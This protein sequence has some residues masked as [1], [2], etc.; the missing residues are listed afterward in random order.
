MKI[1]LLSGGSGTRLW[2]LSND[3]RA[4][5]FLKVLHNQET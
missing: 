5:Q 1:I 3:S 2:P 4:K